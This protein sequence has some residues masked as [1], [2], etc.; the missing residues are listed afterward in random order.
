MA[1][2]TMITTDALSVKYV[3]ESVYSAQDWHSTLHSH[4]FTELLYVTGGSGAMQFE[5]H[6]EALMPHSVIMVNP[7]VRHTE[8]SNVETPMSYIVLGL[9]DIRLAKDELLVENYYHFTDSDHEILPLLRLM[10][11]ETQQQA[12]NYVR[13]TQQ[14][15]GV[16]V[17]LFLRANKIHLV[18]PVDRVPRDSQLIKTYLDNHFKEH[19]TLEELS[20]Q[21][22]F[23]KF[24]IIHV[25]KKA[26]NDTPINYV[27]RK[28]I[29]ASQDLLLTTDYAIGQIA[30][31]TGFDSQSYF[32]Q[33]FKIKTQMSP[34]AYRRLHR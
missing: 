10:L 21:L 22:H 19:L 31:I 28:R 13:I 24:Y 23:D 12:Q 25:F 18:S 32:N 9:D 5:D 27:T 8:T 33:I 16:V 29:I 14:L 7:Y 4:Y 20:S 1:N 17:Q 2:S 15:A 26:F 30:A 11:L 3:R 34:S 6:R